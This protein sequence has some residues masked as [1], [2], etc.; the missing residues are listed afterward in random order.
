MFNFTVVNKILRHCHSRLAGQK[1]N[2]RVANRPLSEYIE[3][4]AP[5]ELAYTT[6]D[7]NIQRTAL[8]SRLTSEPPSA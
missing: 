6:K 4:K 2:M 7:T 5:I 3:T 8:K 1:L